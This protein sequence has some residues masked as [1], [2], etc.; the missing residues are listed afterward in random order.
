MATD[1]RKDGRTDVAMNLASTV[2]LAAHGC[3]GKELYDFKTFWPTDLNTKFCL[4]SL[5]T[6]EEGLHLTVNSD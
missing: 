4:S 5:M 6:N 2:T 1:R 3:R